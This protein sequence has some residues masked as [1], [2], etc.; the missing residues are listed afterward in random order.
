VAEQTAEQPVGR[1]EGPPEEEVE[2]AADI[3]LAAI[4]EVDTARCA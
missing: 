3:L 2:E 4:D 1:P